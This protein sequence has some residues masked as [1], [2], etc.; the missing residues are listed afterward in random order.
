MTLK[1][2]IQSKLHAK[3]FEKSD[4]GKSFM[5]CEGLSKSQKIHE[6]ESLS[7]FFFSFSFF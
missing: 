2:S 5:C 1:D 6:D 3:S 4:G 7:F